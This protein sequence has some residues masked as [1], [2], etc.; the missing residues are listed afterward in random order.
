M[1]EL[2]DFLL[3]NPFILLLI[4][5]W[6]FATFRGQPKGQQ[7]QR[8]EQQRRTAQSNTRRRQTV[9]SRRRS[10]QEAA[11]EMRSEQRGTPLGRIDVGQKPVV[12]SHADHIEQPSVEDQR[13][14]QLEQLQARLGAHVTSHDDMDFSESVHQDRLTPSTTFKSKSSVTKDHIQERFN[15]RGL[16]ESI[17]MAEVLGKPRAKRTHHRDHV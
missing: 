7:Q 15:R 4:I 13:L 10:L 1:D 14:E 12:T 8:R 17:I 9:D 5:G 3:N 16:V 2:F 6:L 11:Q